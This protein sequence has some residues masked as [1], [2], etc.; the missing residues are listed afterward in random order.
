M[1]SPKRTCTGLISRSRP[2]HKS[3]WISIFFYFFS[4]SCVVSLTFQKF[5]G[6]EKEKKFQIVVA[7]SRRVP[8]RPSFKLLGH[9]TQNKKTGFFVPLQTRKWRVTPDTIEINSKSCFFFFFFEQIDLRQPC[10]QISKTRDVF[11]FFFKSNNPSARR[12]CG[13]RDGST[14]TLTSRTDR[15]LGVKPKRSK[16]KGNPLTRQATK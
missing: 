1:P 14:E 7:Q 2:G 6:G 10:A 12:A 11:F 5:S 16:K 15:S 9:T 4:F 3:S 8:F 13:L